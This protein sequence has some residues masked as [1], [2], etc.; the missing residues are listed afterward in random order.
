[1]KINYYKNNCIILL[2]TVIHDR[3]C[4]ESIDL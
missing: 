3:F 4:R 1:M 2:E